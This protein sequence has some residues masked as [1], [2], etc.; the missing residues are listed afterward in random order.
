MKS[1]PVAC[2]VQAPNERQQF[3]AKLWKTNWPLTQKHYIDWW[4]HSGLVLGSWGTGLPA[5]QAHEEV[6]QPAIPASIELRHTDAEFIA[7]NTRYKMS[8]RVWPADILP[9]AWPHIG[10]LPLATYLGAV[11]QYAENNVW[12]QPCM[13]DIEAHPPLKF[14]PLHP[15]VVQLENIVRR[16]VELSGDN[17]LVGMPAI[18][19]GVDVLAE[20]RGT[21]ELLMDMIE[22]PDA[23]HR[24]LTEIQDAYE[25]A[26]GRMY[27]IIKAPDGSMAFGY[28][29][30]WGP[31]KT[32]LCQ[33][34]T[35]SMFSPQM[36]A[37]FVIPYLRRQCEFL[38]WSMFHIDGSQCLAH[39][40]L[41]LEIDQLDAIEYTPDPK[42][43]GGG[44]PHWY[45]LYRRILRAGKSVWVANLVKEQVIPLLDAIG[46]R[47]VYVSV[48][49]LSA[50]D[51]EE[52]AVKIEP[53]R[54]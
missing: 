52:L 44:D 42:V 49:G 25:Q 32:G 19:G 38:D 18:L 33:C 20:L 2:I 1:A 12:Y 22:N 48:N 54:C 10:T 47:G 17:Y 24:R 28:F 46:G 27:D 4:N 36:F 15:Q 3:V 21:A 35:A 40:D 8:R 45:E 14:D 51:A 43:P 39:L 29:M 16:T 37:E 50:A 53:Y 41:L 9:A 31:G 13:T 26:F 11:P 5:K 7:R 23:V 34:D 30:L 6:D